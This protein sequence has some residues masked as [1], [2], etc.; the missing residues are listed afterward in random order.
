MLT[1]FVITITCAFSFFSFILIKFPW[2]CFKDVSSKTDDSKSNYRKGKLLQICCQTNLVL[3]TVSHILFYIFT[4]ER[5]TIK[6]RLLTQ[7]NIM[8]FDSQDK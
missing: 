4:E 5:Y 3:I 6:F 2:R 8:L 1:I 7:S